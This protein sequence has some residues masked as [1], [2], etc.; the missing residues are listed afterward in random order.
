[1]K[2]QVKMLVVFIANT[3]NDDAFEPE[4]RGI[5]LPP[6]GV[7]E[8]KSSLLPVPMSGVL[9]FDKVG[10]MLDYRTLS[11]FSNEPNESELAAIL[12]KDGLQK[13]PFIPGGSG[14]GLII[15]FTLKDSPLFYLASEG[16]V[17][18]ISFPWKIRPSPSIRTRCESAEHCERTI[19][20]EGGT[21]SR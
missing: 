16:V 4:I 15:G 1:M 2:K 14:S 12:L 5:P 9:P 18:T 19:V 13:L 21:Q 11:T 3:G 20:Q 8:D 17:E 7:K 10:L 6:P